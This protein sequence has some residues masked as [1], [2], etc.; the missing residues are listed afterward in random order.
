MSKRDQILSFFDLR[1]NIESIVKEYV[2][3][4]SISLDDRWEIFEKSGF[5]DCPCW[6]QHLESL[7]DD[8]VM[9]DGLVHTDRNQTVSVFDIIEAYNEAR[10]EYEE[11]DSDDD[12]EKWERFRFDPVA[13]KEE[14]L[15]KFIKGW[16]YDW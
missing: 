11:D 12:F 15:F 5:G 4:K 14:C 16:K 8:I 3:D 10:Q 2:Q 1:D 6:V 13:F 9:Y 7:H